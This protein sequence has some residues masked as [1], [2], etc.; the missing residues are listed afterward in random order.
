VLVAGSLGVLAEE[1]APAGGADADVIAERL[2]GPMGGRP[3]AIT[4][5]GELV[6]LTELD[7][8]EQG[9]LD[10]HRIDGTPVLPGVMSIEAFAETAAALCPG[11]RV[12]AIESVDLLAPVKF[13]RDAPRVLELRARVRDGGDG[14]LVADCRL[15]GRRTLAGDREQETIHATGRVRLA[16]Q[17]PDAASAPVP[18]EAADTAQAGRDA[19]YA[20]YFHGPAYQVLDA[21]WRENGRVIGRLAADLPEAHR[22]PERPTVLAPR[23]IELCFQTAGVWE[24]GTS[25]RMALPTHVDRIVPYTAAEPDG[26]A[27]ASVAPGAADGADAIVVDGDGSLLVRLEG[28][29]TIELPGGPDADALAP[30][31]EAMG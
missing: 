11:R 8:T 26:P 10:D 16:E 21:A 17:A 22:P 24:L 25:G 6:V 1:R 12:T 13:H 18:G 30:L 3:T 27:F 19:V 28:Y 29:R 15:I 31:R 23:L 2:A 14:T 7:P 9:F 20:V 4:E 5:A